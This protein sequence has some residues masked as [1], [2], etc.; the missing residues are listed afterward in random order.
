MASEW[1]DNY[2]VT[3]ALTL[4]GLVSGLITCGL[5]W[6]AG[7]LGGYILGGVFGAT[8]TVSL[9]LCGMLRAAWKALWLPLVA[10]AA[11]YISIM[12]AGCVELGLAWMLLPMDR[13]APHESPV[14]LFAGGLIGAFLV[15]GGILTLSHPEVG[16]RALAARAL[17][18]SVPGGALGVVGWALG[19]SL[20]M[21]IWSGVH[22]VG[23]TA[24][25]E[26]FE[27]ALSGTSRQ[28]SL[29]VVWQTGMAFVIGL[30]LRRYKAQSRAKKLVQP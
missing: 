17:W 24:P 9:V 10:A 12:V 25:T 30:M 22:A 23:L 6:P 8:M 1:K 28:Y 27:N 4:A 13:P 7:R 14:A 19:P 26:T 16:M 21:A 2:G 5:V 20:G 29:F 18:W 11:D 3:V 15:L